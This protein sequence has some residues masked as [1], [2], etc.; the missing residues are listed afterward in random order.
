[1][2]VVVAAEEV[3]VPIAKSASQSNVIESS[4]NVR[5]ANYQILSQMTDYLNGNG[6][7]D[8]ISAIIG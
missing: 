1:M 3:H 2:G 7:S 8:F 6:N 4:T 5:Y